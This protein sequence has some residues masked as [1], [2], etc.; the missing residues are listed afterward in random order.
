M[1]IWKP[2]KSLQFIL[3]F[4]LLLSLIAQP[5]SIANADDEEVT[6]NPT[7][8]GSFDLSFPG[9]KLPKGD[10]LRYGGYNFATKKLTAR[11]TQA[12]IVF[13]K[14]TL[15]AR[16]LYDY[17]SAT[18]FDD[19]NSIPDSGYAKSA[20]FS[21]KRVY[22]V[23]TADE[24]FVKL[25]VTKVLTSK[26]E[27]KFAIIQEDSGETSPPKKEEGDVTPNQ[28]PVKEPTKVVLDRLE[29]S[30][31]SIALEP[32][33]TIKVIVYA[34]YS[35]GNE[36]QIT[37]D[38]KLTFRSS[39]S[40][41]VSVFANG[42]IKAGNQLGDAD[43]TFSYGGMKV[44]VPVSVM[45]QKPKEIRPSARILKLGEGNSESI[46]LIAF[47]PDGSRKD[48]TDQAYWE[49]DDSSVITVDRG[50]IE[51]VSTGVA[52]V[53]AEFSGLEVS[54]S[55]IVTED[56]PKPVRLEIS[57][58]NL[59]LLRGEKQELDLWAVYADESKKEVLD[60]VVWTSS[61]SSV[62]KV[63]RDGVI[64]AIGVGKATIKANYNGLQVSLS[65]QVKTAKKVKSLTLDVKTLNLSVSELKK[66][67][68]TVVF[69]DGTKEDVTENAFWSVKNEEISL[70]EN[71]TIQGI[72]A[73]STTIIAKYLD[74]SVSIKV[75]VK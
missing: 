68:L 72:K 49:V 54:I 24:T 5:F 11:E 28:P 64:T 30:E 61:K 73:G 74:K 37:S 65:M 7:K 15:Y 55:I 43:I 57:E 69:T 38:P 8:E 35:D 44:V 71:G 53:L 50:E 41:K 12:D 3:I 48:V 59:S 25:Q 33:K 67:K 75:T 21:T 2:N 29:V 70:V 36:K 6:W 19:I 34:I 20:T 26:I 62:A 9:V 27:F 18:D 13:N 47:Y 40:S 4:A 32:N 14:T 22:L 1:K 51:A 17:G 56:E 46:E 42:L 52:T 31:Q 16:N 58:K 63:S 60:D 39:S 23:E 66:V 45:K 10:E